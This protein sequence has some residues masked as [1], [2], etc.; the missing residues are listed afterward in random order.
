[1]AN[2]SG[3]WT[4]MR[5]RILAHLDKHGWAIVGDNLRLNRVRAG[6][7]VVSRGRPDKPTLYTVSREQLPSLLS[8]LGFGH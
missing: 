1:M 7:I 6:V 5:D 2:T 8:M 4:M 3:G